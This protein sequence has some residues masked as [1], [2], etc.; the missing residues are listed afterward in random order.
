MTLKAAL[1]PERPVADKPRQ[2]RF[3]FGAST[4]FVVPGG[5]L[6]LPFYRTALIATRHQHR[7]GGLF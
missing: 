7:D 1:W 6:G 5:S 4:G 2:T 3:G